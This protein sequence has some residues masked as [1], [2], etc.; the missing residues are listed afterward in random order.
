M[1][2]SCFP[3]QASATHLARNS[4]TR[5]NYLVQFTNPD[6]KFV[7]KIWHDVYERFVSAS[8]LKLK[9]AESFEEKIPPFLDLDCGYLEK[10]SKA[11]CWIEDN[12]D[13][14]AMYKAFSHADD[15]TTLWCE[16]RHKSG[17][18]RKLT[19][20]KRVMERKLRTL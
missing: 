8:A 2:I 6:R 18:K 3:F 15:E 14:E 10:R 4:N 5:Y 16:N 1:K 7:M 17:K 12:E 20:L 13:L 9:M 11:K 19:V